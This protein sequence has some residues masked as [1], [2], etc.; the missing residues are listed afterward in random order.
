MPMVFR[1]SYRPR[2]PLKPDRIQASIDTAM[3][4][5]TSLL[6]ATA[7]ATAATPARPAAPGGAQR[8]RRYGLRLGP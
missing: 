8:Q 6:V 4:L 1:G 5:L 7:S 2:S 3:R